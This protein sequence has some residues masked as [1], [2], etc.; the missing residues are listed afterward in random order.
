MSVSHDLF[1][2]LIPSKPDYLIVLIALFEECGFDSVPLHQYAEQHGT[3][4]G[5][6]RTRHPSI[7]TQIRLN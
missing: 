7:A 5:A 1:Y 6:D 4:H 2:S 3:G